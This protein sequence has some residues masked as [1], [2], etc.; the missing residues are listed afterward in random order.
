MDDELPP[1][2]VGPD[3]PDGPLR[4]PALPR[5]ARRILAVGATIALL[6][7]L[8]VGVLAGDGRAV[9][10]AVFIGMALVVGV[11]GVAIL[12]DAVRNEY[13]GGRVPARRIASG[14]GLLLASPVLL[15]L[16]AGAT[17]TA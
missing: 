13:R 7:A 11:A 16:A 1:L 14:L 17:G 3:G 12:V 5:V 10:A 6:S 4:A 9:A 2:E 8:A 15:I